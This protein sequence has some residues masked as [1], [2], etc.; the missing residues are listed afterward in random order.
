MKIEQLRGGTLQSFV[1]SISKERLQGEA[2][3][4]LLEDNLDFAHWGFRLSHMGYE[5][6]GSRTKVIYD[7]DRCRVRFSLRNL[8]RGAE[9]DELP[10][11][12][13]RLHAPN[14]SLSMVLNGEECWCWHNSVPL[15]VLFLEGYSPKEIVDRQ[16]KDGRLPSPPPLAS[17]DRS[18]EGRELSRIYPP[19]SIIRRESLIWSH[20]GDRLFDLFDLRR[21][22]PWGQYE[23]FLGTYYQAYY[24]IH[25]RRDFPG[26][27]SPPWHRIC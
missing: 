23:E 2:F 18:D 21:P 20:Y 26:G 24:Q 5:K 7:S 6:K 19:A 15:L 25:P 10:V 9:E 12:Y 17:Y 14:D 11:E 3:R 22:G 4:A 16:E 1:S 13:G 8:G 27:T